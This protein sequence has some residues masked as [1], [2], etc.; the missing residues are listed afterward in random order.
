MKP[1]VGST[2]RI[3]RIIV[4][5]ALLSLWFVLSGNLRYL[6]LIGLIPLLT[7]AVRWCPLWAMFRVNTNK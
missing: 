3:I 6:S 2:E 4:G 7:A 5:L 1:N